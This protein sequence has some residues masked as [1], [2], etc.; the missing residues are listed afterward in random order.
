MLSGGDAANL[1][2]DDKL[3]ATVRNGQ[4][5]EVT[6]GQ[7]K[8]QL[9][10]PSGVCFEQEMKLVAGQV[11]PLSCALGPA[12]GGSAAAGSAP[13]AASSGS[14]GG[15]DAAGSG[16]AAVAGGSAGSA[17][18]SAGSGAAGSGATPAAAGSGSGDAT[19]GSASPGSGPTAGNAAAPD[20]PAPDRTDRMPVEDTRPAATERPPAPTR[21]TERPAERRSAR[22]APPADDDLGLGKLQ[23]GVKPGGRNS[24]DTK[25]H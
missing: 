13:G 12:T 21:R 18:P 14:A 10:G 17:A 3:H 22:P 11:A 1:Y 7:R 5:I 24:T 15:G 2:L 25:K 20:H 8:V 16:S 23:G 4:D 19:T 6:P 9:F